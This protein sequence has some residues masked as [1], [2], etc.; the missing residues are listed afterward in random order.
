MRKVETHIPEET[1]ARLLTYLRVLLCLAEQGV[2]TVSSQELGDSCDVKAC[3]IRK[4]LSY[5]GGFG[6]PGVGYDVNGLIEEIRSIL[7]LDR[8]MK[9]ALVGVG[10]I[11]RALLANPQFQTEGFKISVAFDRDPAKLGREVG[12]VLI[13]DVA[14]L[15]RRIREDGIKLAIIAVG[16]SEAPGIAHR[17]A[18]AGVKGILSFA[19]CPLNM[20]EGIKVTCVDLATEM[21]RLVYY[22]HL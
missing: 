13:E 12:G 11:G 22:L 7:N 16:V 3:V 21:A 6:K 15:E 20:P 1:V 5:F 4:D 18:D 2:E 9:T 17:L 10:N 8:V 19:P 14:A